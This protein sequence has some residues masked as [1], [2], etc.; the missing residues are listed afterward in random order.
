MNEKEI[1]FVFNNSARNKYE[2]KSK[3][4]NTNTDFA[5]VKVDC[6]KVFEAIMINPSLKQEEVD[7]MISEIRNNGFTK[8]V[9]KSELYDDPHIFIDATPTS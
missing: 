9:K 1:R 3:L 6:N 2:R 5:K 7:L 4:W 8:S